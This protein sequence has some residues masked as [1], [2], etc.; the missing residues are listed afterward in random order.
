MQI[1]FFCEIKH[2]FP[3]LSC[4][5]EKVI[6]VQMKTQEESKNNLTPY[7]IQLEKLFR[8]FIFSLIYTRKLKKTINQ[9]NIKIVFL[10]DYVEAIGILIFD[11]IKE[12]TEKIL[13]K[14]AGKFQ[15]FNKIIFQMINFNYSNYAEDQMIE[16][17]KR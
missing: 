10:Y 2:E 6:P 12:D 5:R 14:F 13:K 11:K 7:Q 17:K 3:D 15:N 16:G 9:K 1:L 8:K 4:G